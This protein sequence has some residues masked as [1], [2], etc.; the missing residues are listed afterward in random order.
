[1]PNAPKD[2]AAIDFAALAEHRQYLLK[3]ARLE[4]RDG[5]SAEDIVSDVITQAFERRETFRGTSSLRTWL[6]SILKNRIIDLLRKQW[7][8]Q[9][10][11][12]NTDDEN[13]IDRLFD[14]SG[15]YVHMP[16]D[17]RDPAEL[18][19]QDDF[20]A[21]VQKCIDLLPKRI[22]QIFVLREVFG[23]DTRELC[24]D[25]G[26]TTSNVWVQLYRARMMLRTC[27]EQGG[28]G[29]PYAP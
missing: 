6:T 8:E 17:I 15:H 20:L 5:T 3:V 26:L 23:S 4:L 18:S 9:P 22:G 16:S 29:P 12:S 11:E 28:F 7:R 19:Q 2:I 1:M 24:K 25:L 10:L 21:A 13:G 14:A 27:L